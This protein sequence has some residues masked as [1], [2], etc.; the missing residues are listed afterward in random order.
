MNINSSNL[1][2]KLLDISYRS[3]PAVFLFL[4]LKGA[5]DFGSLN[6]QSILIDIIVI[7]PFLTPFFRLGF[8]VISQGLADK[9]ARLA[10]YKQIL[11]VQLFIVVLIQPLFWFDNTA[12]VVTNIAVIMAI[13]FNFGSHLI[14]SGVRG[15]FLWQNGLVNLLLLVGF[16]CSL[17]V[18]KES[19]IIYIQLLIAIIF[20]FTV[21]YFRPSLTLIFSYRLNIGKFTL[22]VLATFLIPLIIWFT[23]AISIPNNADLLILIKLS[24]FISG[25]FGSLLLLNMKSLDLLPR[26]ER[27]H[28]FTQLKLKQQHFLWCFLVIGL[29]AS[30]VLLPATYA[31]YFIAFM[32]MEWCVYRFGHFNL[33]LNHAGRSLSAIYANVAAGMICTV[34]FLLFNFVGD[35]KSQKLAIIFYIF[36]IVVTHS[37]YRFYYVMNKH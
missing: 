31:A 20:I 12:Y 25:M 10:L 5:S 7:A 33:L 26:E 32:M 28:G 14:R 2:S 34:T 3:L 30:L 8:P 4:L 36:S 23:I 29:L 19:F 6:T 24:A 18:F 15:G 22:D 13:C 37:A 16:F 17:W 35:V 11:L 27:L 9:L 1:K 21:F